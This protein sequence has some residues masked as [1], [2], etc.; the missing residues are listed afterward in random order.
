MS[1]P[2]IL[3]QK[4]LIELLNKEDGHIMSVPYIVQGNVSID[5]TKTPL[6]HFCLDNFAFN[7]QLEL[8]NQPALSSVSLRSCSFLR[9]DGLNLK[10]CNGA[11]MSISAMVARW[12][13]FYECAFDNLSLHEVQ[14][15]RNLDLSG[16]DLAEQLSLEKVQCDNLE[17]HSSHGAWYLKVPLVMTDDPVFIRQFELARIPV[18]ASTRAIREQLNRPPEA[19]TV[20]AS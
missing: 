3:D 10:H 17:L 6:K 1:S 8:S 11:F 12:I 4:A 15:G 9:D 13:D 14:V 20:L 7:G 2:T 5:G 19:S 16:L 18:F